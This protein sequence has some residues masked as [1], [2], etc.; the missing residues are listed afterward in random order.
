M[1]RNMYNIYIH[2]TVC[3]CVTKT[4]NKTFLQVFIAVTMP[5]MKVG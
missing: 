2:S 4:A 1:Y 5:T 3:V